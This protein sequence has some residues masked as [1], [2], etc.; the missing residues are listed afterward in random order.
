MRG[1]WKL[2]K[3]PATIANAVSHASTYRD[4]NFAVQ[5]K[6]SFEVIVGHHTSM[7]ARGSGTMVAALLFVTACA[8]P[9]A[10]PET[11]ARGNVASLAKVVPPGRADVSAR[12]LAWAQPVRRSGLPNLHRVDENFY[13]GAQFSSAGAPELTGLKI[14]TVVNLRSLH[15]DRRRLKGQPLRYEHIHTE[16]WHISERDMV[17]FLRLVTDPKA[18]PVFVHCAHGADRT[19]FMTA[20]Y[21]VAVHGWTKDQAVR[22]MIDG[23]YG[24]HAMWGN[25][26]TKLY[27]VDVEQLKRAAGIG[28][29][30]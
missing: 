22:E 16:A 21:R 19:G 24:F 18:Q 6:R 12:P 13:R 25:L 3:S 20:L 15:S 9:Q 7:S 28:A 8:S 29:A 4:I 27:E 14:R 11:V 30:S 1:R 10:P 5:K 17:A 23:G 26:V 2:A